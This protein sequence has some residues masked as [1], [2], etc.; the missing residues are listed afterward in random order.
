MDGG[1]SKMRHGN[2]LSTWPGVQLFFQT[3]WP[4][5]T[6]VKTFRPQE[7]GKMPRKVLITP[8]IIIFKKRE[9]TVGRG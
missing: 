8:S 2:F 5:A 7:G 4:K 9:E 3:R 6:E 1:S